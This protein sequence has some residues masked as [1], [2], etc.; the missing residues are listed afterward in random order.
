MSSPPLRVMFLT[1]YFRPYLGGIER[2]IEQL[3]FKLMES[4]AVEAVGVLTTKYAFPRVAHPEWSDRDATP[5]GISIFR[6]KGFPR[7][8][9][10]FYSVPLVWFSPWQVRQ[11]LEEFKP[12]VIHFVGD[13][14]F[15]GHFWSWFWHHHRAEFVFTPSYHTLP[16]SRW[17]LRPINGF[18]CNVMDSVVSLTQQEAQQVHRDYWASRKKQ[19]VIGWGASPFKS[20]L[21]PLYKGGDERVP[22]FSKGGDEAVPP[23]TEGGSGEISE[24]QGL[25]SPTP[26]NPPLA[27]EG[28]G[29]LRA[30][31][32]GQA[33]IILCVGRLGRHKG[34]E[35][36]LK[37]YRQARSQFQQPTRLVLVGRDEGGEAS[38]RELVRTAGLQDEVIFTGELGDAELAEW[39]S[40]ADLLTLFSHYEAF[41]LVF[42][43]AMVCGLPVLTHDVGANRELLTRGAVVVPRFDEDA[44]VAALARLV[45]ETDYRRQLGREGQEYALREFTWAAVAEKYLKIYQTAPGG[46]S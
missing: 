6:L 26:P 2:A 16:L 12:N 22:P 46:G 41:G 20:P 44:A 32:E 8:S 33:L 13:G 28:M 11:Y 29:G 38:L 7:H 17:W 43:E 3:S 36:L 14:W 27:R 4:P 15:W 39:Y 45:N 1:P 31:G 42:F 19:V 35:W 25:P 40:R 21:T 5:E 9:I 24:G 23:F 30:G 34:Q 10:P 18:I 37:V